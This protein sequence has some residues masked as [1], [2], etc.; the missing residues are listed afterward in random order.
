MVLPRASL[1]LYAADQLC[2]VRNLKVILVGQMALLLLSPCLL[3]LIEILLWGK[4]EED[5]PPLLRL[6]LHLSVKTGEVIQQ[7][8]EGSED[9]ASV[10]SVVIVKVYR[11][12]RPHPCHTQIEEEV[13]LLTT[14]EGDLHIREESRLRLGRLPV[15]SKREFCIG[16]NQLISAGRG[17]ITTVIGND[18]RRSVREEKRRMEMAQ[19]LHQMMMARA[20]RRLPWLA[21]S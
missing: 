12:H 1:L 10:V 15:T 18:V 7:T 13:S 19:H 8:Q 17:F 20:K 3:L 14:I 6:L 5:D 9:L 2:Q 16:G 11:H 4:Q 21:R